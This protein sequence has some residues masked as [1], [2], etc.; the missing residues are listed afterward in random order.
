MGEGLEE[1]A[2]HEAVLRAG[3]DGGGILMILF[4]NLFPLLIGHLDDAA[5]IVEL[6]HHLGDHLVARQQL[7]G[8][9]AGGIGTRKVQ[10]LQHILLDDV[11]GLLQVGAVVDMDVLGVL[12]QVL[13]EVHDLG[14]HFLD[15]GAPRGDRR[16]DGEAEEFAEGVDVELVAVFLQFVVHVERHHH[17]HIH[18]NEL[19]GEE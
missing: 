2:A 8:E 9:V 14:H 4:L 19:G 12:L 5:V 10:M 13:V 3:D 15:A 17:G 16:D 6:A 1:S 11:D 7:D 18:V